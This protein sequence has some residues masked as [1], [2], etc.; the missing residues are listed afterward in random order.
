LAAEHSGDHNAMNVDEGDSAVA[1]HGLNLD[2]MF[3]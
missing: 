3:A 1:R 2:Y